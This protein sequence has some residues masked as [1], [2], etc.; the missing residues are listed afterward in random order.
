MN[1][2]E[3]GN[4]DQVSLTNLDQIFEISYLFLNFPVTQTIPTIL[5]II[6]NHIQF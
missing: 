6:L 1:L 3:F 5:Y 2:E 4:L